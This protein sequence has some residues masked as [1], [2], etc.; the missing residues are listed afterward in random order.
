MTIEAQIDEYW[1]SELRE[2]GADFRSARWSAERD[3]ER[4]GGKTK[5]PPDA[6]RK[7]R[8]RPDLRNKASRLLDLMISLGELERNRSGKKPS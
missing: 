2:I 6:E 3:D 7:Q 4:D 8:E 1:K 5:T